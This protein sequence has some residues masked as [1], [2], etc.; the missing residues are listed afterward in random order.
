[1][2]VIFCIQDRT[3]TVAQ[4]TLAAVPTHPVAVNDTGV[5]AG[6]QPWNGNEVSLEF[7][8]GQVLNP[9]QFGITTALP[10]SA[11]PGQVLQS[12]WPETGTITW[13]TGANALATSAVTQMV[14]ANAYI[15]PTFF[16]EYHTSRGNAYGAPTGTQLQQAIV[17][18]TDY[19]D[20][21]Y[22]FKGVKLLQFLSSGD[23]LDPML[24]FI[25]PWLSPFGFT[26]AAFYVPSTTQQS[27][28]WPR[29]G[30]VDLNG[31]NVYAI[32]KQVA[33]ACAELAFR[34]LSGTILQPDYDPTIVLDGAIIA[35]YSQGVGP[36]K[37]S[38]TLD[39]KMGLGFFPDFPH[40]T[41]LLAKGGLLV[42][43]GGHTIMR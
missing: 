22:R 19:L 20:Q 35:S 38:Q 12:G 40:I 23:I 43:G 21:Y 7:T 42:A 18:A 39:T 11:G 10:N 15:T 41:R 32:P 2:T 29:Q 24:P 5:L 30:V 34:Q 36:I 26:T 4:L 6:I 37:V 27:T 25:D 8:V 13:A 17:Q 1:M 9:T 16:K 28:E 3:G 33:F 31:D 14:P